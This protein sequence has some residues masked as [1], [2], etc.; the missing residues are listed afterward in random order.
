MSRTT[1]VLNVTVKNLTFN[2]VSWAKQSHGRYASRK[3]ARAAGEVCRAG[4]RA[5]EWGG[6]ETRPE[7]R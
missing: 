7:S 1:W 5:P 3:L 4:L 2:P 6:E